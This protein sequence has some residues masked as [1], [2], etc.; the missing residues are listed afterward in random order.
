MQAHAG[1]SKIVTDESLRETVRH[2]S[3]E[4][5]LQSYLEDIWLFDFHRSEERRVGKECM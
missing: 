1:F 3:E 2:G 5:P 4:Y